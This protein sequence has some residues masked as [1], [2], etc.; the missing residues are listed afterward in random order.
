MEYKE[1][2]NYISMV[3]TMRY[4]LMMTLEPCIWPKALT[5]VEDQL[6]C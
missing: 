3:M 6:E 5:T 4:P 1:R 2:P